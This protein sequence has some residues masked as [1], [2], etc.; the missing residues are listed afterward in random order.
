[1][2]QNVINTG[3]KDIEGCIDPSA[4]NFNPFATTACGPIAGQQPQPDLGGIYTNGCCEYSIQAVTGCMD[5][6]ANNYD[7]TAVVACT[8]C[9]DYGTGGSGGIGQEAETIKKDNKKRADMVKKIKEDRASEAKE[10]P[11]KK[12]GPELEKRIIKMIEDAWKEDALQHGA[13]Y[14]EIKVDQGEESIRLTLVHPKYDWQSILGSV[15]KRLPFKMS[16]V[17]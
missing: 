8:N 15:F 2:A 3:I 17:Q 12:K 13:E 11:A 7:P 10:K 5:S 6:N 16:V 4:L 14:I 9:C 1:M